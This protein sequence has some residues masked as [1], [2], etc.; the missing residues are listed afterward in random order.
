MPSTAASHRTRCSSSGGGHAGLAVSWH[1]AARGIEHVVLEAG[2]V[3]ESWRSGRWDSFAI[4]TPSWSLRLPGDE[5]ATRS[6]RTGSCCATPGWSMLEAYVAPPRPAGADRQPGLRPQRAP[7]DGLGFRAPDDGT[8][9]PTRGPQR[10]HRAGFQRVGQ[11]PGD[12]RRGCR[13]RCCPMHAS[14][15]RRAGSCCRRARCSSSAAPSRAP[16]SR[17]TSSRRAATVLLSA[18][19]VPAARGDTAVGT[20][21]SGWS[22][23]A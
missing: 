16:R 5:S 19:A 7:G 11:H 20:S 12:R 8:D 6:P 4:N 13:R 15:Y 17:R 23:R 3:G 18:S 21:S 10:R 22:S 9:D 1:L 2:R 14:D